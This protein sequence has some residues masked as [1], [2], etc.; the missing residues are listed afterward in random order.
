MRRCLML[1]TLTS[2]E[3][4][5][6]ANDALPD[7]QPVT[8][9]IGDGAN[10]ISMI[11][12]AHIGVGVMGKEGTQAVRSSDYAI[13]RLMFRQKVLLVHGHWYYNRLVILILY[14]FYKNMAFMNCQLLYLLFNAFSLK[15]YSTAF[16]S[17]SSTCCS[18]PHP[19]LCS[20]LWSRTCLLI[21]FS[22][23]R[24]S[25]KTSPATP[26]Y[27]GHPFASGSSSVLGILLCASLASTSC[28]IWATGCLE[29]VCTTF[30]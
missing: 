19:F 8:L 7:R 6:C 14:F 27:N 22:S 28:V 16:H 1:S 25:T 20:V 4:P 3:K 21:V 17:P 13:G 9:A 23:T 15:H 2:A 24:P 12:E 5:G 30:F 29:R 11:Q 26:C 10:D 18:R